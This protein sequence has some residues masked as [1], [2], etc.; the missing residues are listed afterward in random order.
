MRTVDPNGII[1]F[2]E[3]VERGSFRGAARAL[4]LPKSTV[5]QR[6]AVLEEQL[7]VQLLLRTTRTVM[8]TDIGASYQREV[9]PAVAA[10]RD[11]AAL[12]NELQAHPSGRL[13]MSAPVELGQRLMGG[14]LAAFAE[15]YPQV[16]LELEL[17]DREV[18]MVEEGHDLSIRVGPLRD[19]QLIAR[20]LGV[21]AHVGI[22]GSAAYLKKAGR[23][24]HP[25]ELSAHRCLSMGSSTSPMTWAF[26]GTRPVSIR[27]VIAVN[28]FQVLCALAAAG[29]GLARLPRAQANTRALVE[30]LEPFAPAPHQAFAVYPAARHPSAALR[31]MLTVLGETF[32]S[33]EAAVRGGEL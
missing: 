10:L 15:R 12:V 17:T 14:V 24:K 19:S 11:A 9:A 30:V 1:A 26:S 27:P 13:R 4:A 5:S 18:N 28:S 8:L 22:F 33:C 7:G 23:P 29:A 20:K 25:R 2:L 32:G 31:A 3:V 16:K 6:V 21:P